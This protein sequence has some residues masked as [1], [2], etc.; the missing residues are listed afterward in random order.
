[1][2]KTINFQQFCD[3]FRGDYKDYFSYEGKKALFEYLECQEE[4]TGEQIDFDPI[5][6]CVEYAEYANFTEYKEAYGEKVKT[7]EELE[8]NTQV[9]PIEGMER[10]II[11][12]Y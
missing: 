8:D 9:I 4:I 7:I 1:M 5:A 12:Q 3:S 10:F 11:Q 6:L 2:K